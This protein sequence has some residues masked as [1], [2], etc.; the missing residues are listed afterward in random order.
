MSTT[1]VLPKP[2]AI[3][4]MFGELFGKAVTTRRTAPLTVGASDGAAIATYAGDDGTVR[5]LCVCDAALACSAGAALTMLPA[6]MAA[7]S[8]KAGRIADTI[9]EN[10]R[11]VLNIAHQFFH[12]PGTPHMI[13]REVLVTP[14]SLPAHVAQV[15]GKPA[16]RLDVEL[17][18][19]GYGP[20]RMALLL[21]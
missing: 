6:A 16:G 19:H 3:A 21:A 1:P 15:L 12:D 14:C 20:G 7:Q 9:L 8:S 10:L 18:I 5:A 2:E 4:R 13:L 11:E 17:A